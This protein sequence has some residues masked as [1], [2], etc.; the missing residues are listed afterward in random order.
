MAIIETAANHDEA[1]NKRLTSIH[2]ANY[3]SKIIQTEVMSCL[4]DIVP[5][6]ITKDE[7]K[8]VKSSVSWQMKQTKKKNRFLRRSDTFSVELSRRVFSTLNLL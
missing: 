8:K 5:T 2:N 6:K 7:G 3:T 1:V 4:A